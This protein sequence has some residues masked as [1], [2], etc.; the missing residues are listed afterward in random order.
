MNE[1]YRL[2]ET[3]TIINRI[4]PEGQWKLKI[5]YVEDD[6]ITPDKTM[7]GEN[8]E[9]QI[10]SIGNPPAFVKENGELL[11][12]NRAL[13]K[14]PT[15]GSIGSKTIYQIGLVIIV[16]GIVLLVSRKHVFTKNK[17]NNQGK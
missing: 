15:S 16:L 9:L 11:L 3:K 13:F 6:K 5:E 8:I 7:L 12:P 17:T 4:K 14:F 10:T 1:E 2:V